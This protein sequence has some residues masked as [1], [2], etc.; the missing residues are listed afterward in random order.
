MEVCIFFAII[1]F[2][3]TYLLY[4]SKNERHF[5]IFLIRTKHFL[6]IINR[7]SRL[8][9]RFW[10]F[11]GDLSIFISF[12]GLG[13]AYLSKYR[14]LNKNLSII[15]LLFG[16]I[17][18]MLYSSGILLVIMLIL[19]AI[20]VVSLDKIKSPVADFITSAVIMS[21]ISLKMARLEMAILEGIF[22]LLVFII[23][24]LVLHAIDISYGKTSLPGVSPILPG[25]EQGRIGFV[26]PGMNIFIP[27]GY[28]LV[29]IILLVIIHESSHG[30]LAR[31]NNINLKSTGLL[32]LGIIPIGAF[33][34]PDEEEFRKSE[35]IRRMRVL[36]VGS[37][38]NLITA[39]LSLFMFAFLIL[40]SQCL[41][42]EKSNSEIPPG[43]EVIAM[44]NK[45]IIN[46]ISATM[47]N[48]IFTENLYNLSEFVGN[49]TLVLKTDDR[50]FVLNSEELKGMLFSYKPRFRFELD[51]FGINVF[52]I[53]AGIL[54]W[55]YF[56]NLNV[57]LVNLLPIVPFDGGKMTSEL[58]SSLNI[59]KSVINVFTYAIIL[60]CLI[61]I[62][63]NA[64]PLLDMIIE[65]ISR[66]NYSIV[67]PI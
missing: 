13:A 63:I 3:G 55:T 53:I 10:N 47:A 45:S 7:L 20:G 66:M 60:V 5:I 54:F 21:A 14:R 2:I 9:P 19:L 4:R 30:I 51:I 37:I 35:G 22:G 24:P 64:L 16:I 18:I 57:G 28:G 39:I 61:V 44:T 41:I 65:F 11:I 31:S 25:S 38:S 58:I 26:V 34:E 59:N 40:P 62:L 36:A 6:N 17:M 32:T 43:T 1:F 42:V 15:L 50:E 46:Y 29:A 49:G 23:T 33:V 8:S 52:S 48:Y 12:S 67:L 56:F 27:L